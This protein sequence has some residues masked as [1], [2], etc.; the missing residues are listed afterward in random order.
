M[1]NARKEVINVDE[2]E[3]SSILTAAVKELISDNEDIIIDSLRTALTNSSVD[4]EVATRLFIRS[5]ELSTQL[6]VSMVIALL[7]EAEVVGPAPHERVV[8]KP[9]LKLLKN[10]QK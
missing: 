2:I 4:A 5:I 1:F 10:K 6:S 8:A 9:L 7:R 3:F